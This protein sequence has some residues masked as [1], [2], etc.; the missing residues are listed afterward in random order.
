M[1]FRLISHKHS[2]IEYVV[3]LLLW[4]PHCSVVCFTP[5]WVNPLT[6]SRSKTSKENTPCFE[7]ICFL[8]FYEVFKCFSSVKYWTVNVWCQEN[9]FDSHFRWNRRLQFIL[10]KSHHKSSSEFM[11]AIRDML[12]FSRRKFENKSIANITAIMERVGT[13]LK[14]RLNTMTETCILAGKNWFLLQQIFL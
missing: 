1:L 2:A 8:L 4:W 7:V 12:S 9:F 14:L 13:Y 10:D 6:V 11:K 5:L 3:F